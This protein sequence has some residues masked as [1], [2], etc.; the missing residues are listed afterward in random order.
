MYRH[1]FTFLG[2]LYAAIITMPKKMHNTGRINTLHCIYRKFLPR[3]D[4][5]NI[6]EKQMFDTLIQS[7]SNGL[8]MNIEEWIW[9]LS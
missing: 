4:V 5:I 3:Q 8:R 9:Q 6:N 1:D 2:N 7:G